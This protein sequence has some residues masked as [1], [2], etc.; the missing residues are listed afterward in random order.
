[1]SI[2]SV[3]ERLASAAQNELINLVTIFLGSSVGITKNSDTFLRPATLK[4]LGMGVI[5]FAVS[6]A[7]GVLIPA[8]CR[9]WSLRRRCDTA[10]GT[11]TRRRNS[12]RPRCPSRRTRR[13]PPRIS[14][15]ALTPDEE[16]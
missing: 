14:L 9:W 5:A 10:R 7:C 2:Q 1:M 16:W 8:I 15:Q 11:H 4:I 13:R 6:T 12:D 3:V